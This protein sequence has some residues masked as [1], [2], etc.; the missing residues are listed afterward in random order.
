LLWALAPFA[1]AYS[2]FNLFYGVEIPLVVQVLASYSFATYALW[3]FTGLKAN[4]DE[5]GIKDFRKC[6]QLMLIQIFL[7]PIFCVLEGLGVAWG[8]ISQ[9]KGF[10]V[11]KK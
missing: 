9:A 11:V 2:I 7:L 5:H 1:V 10:E 6:V 4:M 3:Y 8:L